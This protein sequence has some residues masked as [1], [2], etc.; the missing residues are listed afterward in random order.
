MSD[1][2]FKQMTDDELNRVIAT[3]MG[4]L[5][6]AHETYR[7]LTNEV[8]EAENERARRESPFKVGDRVMQEYRDNG[9]VYEITRIESSFGSPAYYGR[10]VLKNGGLHKN[11]FSLFRKLK[12][13]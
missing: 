6:L 4:E 7:R 9:A 1:V 2:D 11:E 13:I 12:K 3:K 10:K 8:Q 5:R